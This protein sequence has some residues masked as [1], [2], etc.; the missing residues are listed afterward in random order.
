MNDAVMAAIKRFCVNLALLVAAL[1]VTS[2]AA[3]YALRLV[4]PQQLILKRSDVWQPAD[5][6]GWTHHPNV[7]TTIN[8]GEGQVR[9][10]T[11]AERHRVGLAGRRD[12]ARTIL[13]LGDSFMEALQVEYEQSVA[14][15]LESRLPD[16]L[17]TTV[18]V[19]NAGVGGWDPDQYLIYARRA[20]A[21]A[22]Y[23]LVI[24]SLFMENDII[25][26]P[27]D[28]VPPRP[29][30]QVHHFRW[31]RRAAWREMVDAWFYPVN[32]FFEVRSHLFVFIKS[33]LQTPFMRLGLTEAAFGSVYLKSERDSSRWD[34]TTKI[35]RQISDLAKERGIPTLVV[36]IPA[37]YQVDTAIF[38]QYAR[39]FGIDVSQVDLE[40][41]NRL[42]GERLRA[43]GLR[44]IDAL[45]ALRSAFLAG[46]RPYGH[47]DRHFSPAGHAIVAALIEEPVA[48]LL[49]QNRP[50]HP[51]RRPRAPAAVSPAGAAGVSAGRAG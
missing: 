47:V 11:D 13:L 46:A 26:E 45:P 9:F 36:L 7:N 22:R 38:R 35:C 1:A 31:P 19:R 2:L 16:L 41:P 40:Q 49:R 5:T 44:V 27:R 3:E 4:A 23:D 32:D 29:P 37:S 24:I 15:L 39:G 28:V 14:G 21:A 12:G 8:T 10:V 30:T 33:R 18:A 20:L 48:D 43:A 51:S 6:L 50:S 34:T 25:P 42:M 17:G